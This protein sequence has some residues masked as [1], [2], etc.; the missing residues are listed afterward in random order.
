MCVL[1]CLIVC[2]LVVFLMSV[3]L[4]MWFELS[5]LMYVKWLFGDMI[6]VCV[7]VMLFVICSGVLLLLCMCVVL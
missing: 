6:I 7:F 1:L 2:N 3:K 5:E 4:N